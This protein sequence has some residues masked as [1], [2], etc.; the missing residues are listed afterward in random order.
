MPYQL[1][2][3]E[4]PKAAQKIAAALADGK[5]V[6]GVINGV[7]YYKVTHGKKDL[8]VSSAV[9]HLYVLAERAGNT[10]KYPVFDVEWK[11]TFEV[12]DK[13]E[14]SRKYL[15]AIKKLS[16][17]A[18]DFVVATDYDIEGEV[19]GL[20]IIRSACKQKDAKRMKFS[21]LTKPDLEKAYENLSPRLDWKF[22]EAG[23]TRHE[24]DWIWGINVSRALTASVKAAGAFKV[25]S[26]GRVQGP[27]LKIIIDREREIKA[28]KSTPYWQL[29]LLGSANS[30]PIDAW[31]S[32]DKFWDQPQAQKI[33]DKT[34]GKKATV[35][36]VDKNTFTQAPPHPF[37]LTTLQTE[38]YRTLS[39]A[40]KQTLMLAQSLYTD[41]YISYPRTSSHVLPKE[42][43]YGKILKDISKLPEYTEHCKFLLK[44][45]D[46]Q[47]N[48]GKK[49]DPAH[50]A[51]YPTGELPKNIEEKEQKLYDLIV[52]RFLATFGD[53]ATRETNEIDI[54]VNGET[55]MAKGMRTVVK[56][57][58]ELYGR[59]A[60][61]KDEE[62]PPVKEGQEIKVDEIKMHS[63]ETQP[64]KRYTPASII[65][66][67]TKRN[68][69]TKTTRA[70]IVDSLQNRGYLKG[71]QAIEATELG[72]HTTE[73]L[74]KY[75]PK[76]LDEKLTRHFE[77]E[78]DQIIEGKK[79]SKEVLEEARDVLSKVL[80]DFKKSEKDIG[81]GL[82]IANVET[83]RQENLIGNCPVCK[84]GHLRK[85]FSRKTKKA[86]I[87]CDRYPECKT[88][89]PL[90][91]GLI[92]PQKKDCLKCGVPVIKVIRKG[93]RPFEMCLNTS[94]ETKALWGKKKE[95]KPAEAKA[96]V[97]S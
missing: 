52:R 57:W 23:E 14:Y 34:K 87:A 75:A 88:T 6:K 18:D 69:G 51:V 22:A 67:L 1:I 50:P 39:I 53:P 5:P 94:C 33:F 72:L 43:G 49:T 38:A 97:A 82:R 86:F 95:E 48:N 2:I 63:K 37:D 3:T 80:A 29:E 89:F 35:K 32:E 79:T 84:T 74:E 41:G 73:I 70:M 21:T 28:F 45:K 56:G 36:K 83:R 42:I 81:A 17:D 58:H 40:P 31:H 96:E 68:L 54:D 8:V 11:P 44:K 61:F 59:Y 47:P 65:K 46:L 91:H 30:K 55:F 12:N 15:E 9:G 20:N 25:L 24:M 78:M 60:T 13:S 62:L 66:E 19:I 92:Q 4:K 16:K 90:P 26:S 10:W 77:I 85:L 93:K 7:A 27:A 71:D 76:I 64:P